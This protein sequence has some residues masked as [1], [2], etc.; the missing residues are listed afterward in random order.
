MILLFNVIVR[1]LLEAKIGRKHIK[2]LAAMLAGEV[3]MF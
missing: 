2:M 1:H 3:V